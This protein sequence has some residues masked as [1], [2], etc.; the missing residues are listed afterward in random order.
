MARCKWYGSNVQGQQARGLWLNS[1][2]LDET[3]D[4][5]DGHGQGSWWISYR[6]LRH[7]YENAH[8][9]YNVMLGLPSNR[10]DTLLNVDMQRAQEAYQQLAKTNGLLAQYLDPT[11]AEKGVE[12]HV[13]EYARYI[14][15]EEGWKDNVLMRSENVT[16]V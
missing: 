6:T 5:G 4:L 14:R 15:K 3:G 13:E 8:L 10:N 2:W 12:F 9:L 1:F 11:I 16:P 7:S